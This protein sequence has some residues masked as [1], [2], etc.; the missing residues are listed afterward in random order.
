MYTYRGEA[1][2]GGAS[3]CVVVMACST[4]TQTHTHAHAHRH[5]DRRTDRQTDR[6]TDTQVHG[7]CYHKVVAWAAS[8]KCY[9]GR[10][11]CNNMTMCQEDA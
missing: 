1:S 2:G 11:G 10:F 3:C 5:A 4:H 6:Q 8:Q 9:S 7:K